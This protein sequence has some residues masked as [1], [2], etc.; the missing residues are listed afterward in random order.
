MNTSQ[1]FDVKF[2]FI[3]IFQ[4]FKCHKD[5]VSMYILIQFDLLIDVENCFLN[6]LLLFFFK[7]NT[8]TGSSE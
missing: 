2:F 3:H 1:L 4:F 6:L 8:K 7:G 5:N